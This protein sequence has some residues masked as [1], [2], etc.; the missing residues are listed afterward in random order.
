MCTRQA[1]GLD[2]SGSAPLTREEEKRIRAER[3]K[4]RNKDSAKE[5][6]RK[7]AEYMVQLEKR[8]EAS[9]Q[10]QERCSQLEKEN[11]TLT[12]R[13]SQMQKYLVELTRSLPSTGGTFP[14]MMLLMTFCFAFSPSFL[15][16]TSVGLHDAAHATSEPIIKS[17]VLLSIPDTCPEQPRTSTPAY[18]RVRRGSLAE[19]V[20]F[21][22]ARKM[23]SVLSQAYPRYMGEMD[24]N[25]TQEDPVLTPATDNDGGVLV[26]PSNETQ[27]PTR[28]IFFSDAGAYESFE[29]VPVLSPESLVQ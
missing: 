22:G 4:I 17:R 26:D 1:Q 15:T 13:L 20:S 7:K 10:L 12:Q 21:L 6:R 28:E 29:A 8:A 14:L 11:A 27:M 18:L 9:S 2:V 5:S 24:D 19:G 3:R 25:G 16:G 23:P